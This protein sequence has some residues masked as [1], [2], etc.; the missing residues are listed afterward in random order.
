MVVLYG[1]E[2]EMERSL[3]TDFTLTK[4]VDNGRTGGYN[5][6][7]HFVKYLNKLTD[8]CFEAGSLLHILI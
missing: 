7:N 5:K 4:H 6:S 3:Q 8:C 2:A 1:A